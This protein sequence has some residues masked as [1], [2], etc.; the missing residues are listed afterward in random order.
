MQPAE[1]F[2]QRH[3]VIYVGQ[4][5][6]FLLGRGFLRL[7]KGGG[8]GERHGRNTLRQRAAQRHIHGVLVQQYAAA[9]G[10]S[11]Q[12]RINLPV[13]PQGNT[14]FVQGGGQIRAEGSGRGIE[15]GFL[16]R[17]QG[18]GHEYGVIGHIA[19]AQIEKPRN[20]IQSGQQMTVGTGVRHGAA[21]LRQ[22][23]AAAFAGIDGGQLPNRRGGEGRTVR[24]QFAHQISGLVKANVLLLQ[25]I[26]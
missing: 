12:I 18:V 25:G 21:Q 3:A 14:V 20:V 13:G 26:S 4:A 15:D 5:H 23:F 2:C 9:G 17:Q 11:G 24:P 10:Q 16:R 6:I 1:Q 7:A 22:L 8:I 19:A